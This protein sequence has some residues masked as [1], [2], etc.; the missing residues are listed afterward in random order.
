MEQKVTFDSNGLNLA[1]ILR[2]PESSEATKPLPA[3][4]VT[5]PFGGVKEQTASVYAKALTDLG[6]VTLVYDAAY[7][8]ESEGL[9]RY[10]EDPFARVENIKSAVTYL[11]T[12]DEV[13]GDKIGALGI[14]AAGGYVPNAAQ[15]DLRIKAVATVSGA[16]MGLLFR[17]GLG[18]NA[19]PEVL[20]QMLEAS[21]N[22][23]NA[24]ARG[25]APQTMS[26]VPNAP[27]EV[28]ADTPN[29][30][31]EGTDYYRTPRAQH[32]NAPNKCLVRSVDRIV[33][34]S[35]YDAIDMISPRPLLMIA[36]T[37][38]DTR[39][40][41]ELAVDRAKEPKELW[42]VE[43]ATHID[44]YDKPEFVDPAANK[45]GNFFHSSLG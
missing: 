3:V 34:Y 27:D 16:D 8:G 4:V 32:P 19:A 28:T 43:G 22:A 15:T 45:L 10:L 14:C 23:R 1:G 26:I 12:L 20:Q 42:L 24:E 38:A 30:Y 18:G 31:R 5:H 6:F 41:S 11:T 35:S 40:F 7:Q 37:E 13:D 9:P 36:G 2:F 25:E 39:Y 33:Q 44:L 17:E 21:V 29:L